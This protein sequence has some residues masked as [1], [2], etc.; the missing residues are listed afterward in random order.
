MLRYRAASGDWN[1]MGTL[2]NMTDRSLYFIVPKEGSRIKT[3][4][5]SSQ[6]NSANLLQAD[7]KTDDIQEAENAD[8]KGSSVQSDQFCS[9]F[10][11]D[12]SKDNQFCD[13]KN[14]DSTVN[15]SF[16]GEQDASKSAKFMVNV[17][18]TE[19]DKYET[20]LCESLG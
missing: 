20:F 2:G 19:P 12:V 4:S 5:I 14:A 16:S 11:S 10:E 3:S 9:A 8:D 1:V 7:D 6:N 17:E 15:Q 18:T 13:V